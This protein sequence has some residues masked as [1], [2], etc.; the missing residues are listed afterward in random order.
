MREDN[1]I[2]EI[3]DYQSKWNTVS[4]TPPYRFPWQALLHKPTGRQNV[5]R[6]WTNWNDTF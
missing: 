5:E 6:S 3:R 4:R 1:I 2:E